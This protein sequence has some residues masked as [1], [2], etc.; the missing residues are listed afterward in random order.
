MDPSHESPPNRAAGRARRVLLPHRRRLA[1]PPALP[2][3]TQRSE[4]DALGLQE[5]AIVA[6]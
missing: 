4:A 3:A 6:A 1:P 5:G 2:L